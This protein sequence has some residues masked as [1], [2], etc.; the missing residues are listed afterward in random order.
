MFLGKFKHE[1]LKAKM[2]T[3]LNMRT[4]ALTE[5]CCISLIF[6][7]SKKNLR[8]SFIPFQSDSEWRDRSSSTENIIHVGLKMLLF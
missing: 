5:G 7:I 3:S 4:F 1:Y 8:N 6:L 2:I